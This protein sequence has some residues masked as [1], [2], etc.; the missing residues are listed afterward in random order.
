MV[1]LNCFYLECRRDFLLPVGFLLSS[2]D[3]CSQELWDEHVPGCA[4][5]PRV[6][7]C[8]LLQV[9]T[10]FWKDTHLFS[11]VIIPEEFVPLILVLSRIFSDLVTYI[12]CT[13]VLS[14]NRLFWTVSIPPY[15]S[16]GRCRTVSFV[17]RTRE[18]VAMC[19]Q[20]VEKGFCSCWPSLQ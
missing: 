20:G 4:S 7:G 3:W 5:A 2:E 15:T 16:T 18:C 19:L 11:L 12:I 13:F 6:W 10:G 1:G 14:V 8:I 17:P 9:S